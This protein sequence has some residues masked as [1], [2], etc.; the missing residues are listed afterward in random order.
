MGLGI[1]HVLF[2][3]IYMDYQQ[4]NIMSERQCAGTKHWV[5]TQF[6]REKVY[7]LEVCGEYHKYNEEGKEP[8][9]K[10]ILCTSVYLKFKN[11]DTNLVG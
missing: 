1:L 10:Y 7:N 6:P 4:L 8:D 9:T 3:E 2:L 5:S 11:R